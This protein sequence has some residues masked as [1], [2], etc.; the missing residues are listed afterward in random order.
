M[1]RPRLFAR[2]DDEGLDDFDYD[3]EHVELESEI[4]EY[5]SED[6]DEDMDEVDDI[7]NTPPE[8]AS[9]VKKSEGEQNGSAEGSETGSQGTTPAEPTPAAP[10][11]PAK[12]AGSKGSGKTPAKKAPTQAPAKK[13]PAK[14]SPATKTPAKK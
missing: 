11:K 4:G 12:K 13:A 1:Y 6:E 9:A 7:E 8:P 3:D 2:V 14:K 5:R 10:K